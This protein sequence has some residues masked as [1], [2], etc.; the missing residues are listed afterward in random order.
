M[1]VEG[2]DTL[3]ATL[4]MNSGLLR[5]GV[6]AGVAPLGMKIT[7]GWGVSDWSVSMTSMGGA[8][9][10]IVVTASGD[11]SSSEGLDSSEGFVIP[12]PSPP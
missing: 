8:S 3:E 5:L 6:R 4:G 2:V 11:E 9:V 10:D 7:E 1:V 12:A